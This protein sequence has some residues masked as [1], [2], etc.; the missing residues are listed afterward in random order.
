MNGFEWLY[1]A[2]AFIINFDQSFTH[3]SRIFIVHLE[4][5]FAGWVNLLNLLTIWSVHQRSIKPNIVQT[6]RSQSKWVS[7]L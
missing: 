1:R 7:E 4:Y 3:F 6:I 2:G 5:D